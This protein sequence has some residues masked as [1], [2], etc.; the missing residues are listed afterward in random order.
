MKML[1]APWR[2]EYIRSKKPK[3][4]ILCGK[5]EETD[6]TGNYILYRG[7]NNFVILNAYPYNPG[8][9]MVAP[10]RHLASLEDFSDEELHEH[11][12]IV[13]RVVKVLREVV[14]PA[15]FNLGVNIGKVAGTGIEDHVHTHIVPR[16][17]GDTN[18]MPVAG[19]MRVISEGLAATYQQLK[20]KI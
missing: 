15:G 2:M 11:Y 3:G 7:E 14:N 5:P 19:E 12:T 1:W 8:H 20:G 6:D 17:L 10:Y 16:W 18:F 13:S 4:C 9:V